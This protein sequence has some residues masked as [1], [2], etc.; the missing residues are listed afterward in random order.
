MNLLAS[1]YMRYS[2]LMIRGLTFHRDGIADEQLAK[3]EAERGRNKEN[4][5]SQSRS[6]SNSST[7]TVSTTGSH[8]RIRQRYKSKEVD[9]SK[10]RQRSSSS[11]AASLATSE[12]SQ[13]QRRIG[14]ER[15]IRRRH[16][17]I[18]PEKRGR[19]MDQN[20]SSRRRESLSKHG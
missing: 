3:V 9:A 8:S 18:S 5:K 15:N 2:V 20:S 14:K 17:S 16:S 19:S 12:S 1:Q 7:S 13:A 4:G 10:K 11:S 6:M